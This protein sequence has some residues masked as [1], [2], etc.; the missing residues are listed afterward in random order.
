[1]DSLAPELKRKVDKAAVEI[2][3]AI[4]ET[5]SEDAPSSIFP[6]RIRGEDSDL[7]SPV[8]WTEPGYGGLNALTAF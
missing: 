6:R 5:T 1:M 3:D 4:I 2:W 7:N 8:L